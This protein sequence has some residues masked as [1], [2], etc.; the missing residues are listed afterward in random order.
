MTD[1]G[2]TELGYMRWGV[3]SI[4]EWKEFAT[5]IC[6]MEYFEEDGEAFLRTDLQHH[7]IRLIED[8]TDDCLAFGLR[9]RSRAALRIMESKLTEAGVKW[10]RLGADEAHARRVRE[11]IALEDPA[12]NPIEIYHSPRISYHKP[13][14][15]GRPMFGK[16]VTG[17]AG[18]GH[19]I[20]N[21]KDL[22]ASE[23]F[24][25]LLG[26]E[27][28]FYSEPVGP[29]PSVAFMQ[30]TDPERRDHVIA[31]GL[32]LT[33]RF[34]HLMIQVEHL[35]DVFQAWELVKKSKYKI[36]LDIG[37]HA[38]DGQISFYFTSP[39]GFLIEIGHGGKSPETLSR[40]TTGDPWGH[41]MTPGTGPELFLVDM[42][43]GAA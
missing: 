25:E 4:R 7:R 13:L 16:F 41:D 12:G 19:I 39:S 2:V 14:H 20:A 38:N 23:N 34:N 36:A 5:A 21:T 24:Y 6:G 43:G 9:V 29:M 40:M 28:C 15:T 35:D 3:S 33:K 11:V 31:V 32:A 1:Y 8:G 26:L 18:L 42:G 30:S 17:N 37:R 10:T 27:A 22:E